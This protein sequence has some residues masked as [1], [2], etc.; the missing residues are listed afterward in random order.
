[1]S[2]SHLSSAANSPGAE[3]SLGSESNTRA[4]FL[5]AT[6]PHRLS[7]CISNSMI[8]ALSLSALLDPSI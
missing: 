2:I 6:H 8:V 7:L 3:N 1:M 5:A 4:Q